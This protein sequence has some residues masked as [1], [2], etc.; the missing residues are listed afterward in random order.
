MELFP[1]SG[2]AKACR[3]CGIAKPPSAF[4]AHPTSQDRRFSRC[5]E[6]TRALCVARYQ[7][8]P[9]RVKA[10]VRAD[11]ERHPTHRT[12]RQQLNAAVS[13]G[14]LTKPADCE[15]CG[16]A[17]PSRLIHGHHEDYARPLD[18]VWLCATC[19]GQRHRLE[20]RNAAA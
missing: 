19:H 11:H 20:A 1:A 2:H 3:R 8:D 6:C 14:R 5:I 15:D 18:V 4:Y 9:A 17:F 16:R 12:A 13:R 10:I 7:R